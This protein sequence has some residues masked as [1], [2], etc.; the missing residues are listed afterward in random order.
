MSLALQSHPLV[1]ENMG[2][3][4]ACANRF[5]NRGVPYDD[6]FQAGCVG[7]I[8]AA[9]GFDDTRGFKF[10]TY[11]VP[12][13]LGEIKRIFRDGGSVKIGR[14]AKEKGRELLKIYE[15]L[16]DEKGREPDI[17]EVARLAGTEV[18]EAAL[19]LSASLPAVSPTSREDS[20][21]NDIPVESP[22]E[23]CAELLDLNDALERLNDDERQL[24]K[25][26]YFEFMTQCDTAKTLGMTQV[27]V[28]R[29]EKGIL[30][31][32]R[33]MLEYDKTT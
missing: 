4:H 15:R 27:Q 28:S 7:L 22:E 5:R 23:S 17:S 25:C 32:L 14:A 21:E 26:R 13:I 31:K 30:L 10:S 2:L 20:S 8:K 12:A 3:V 24:I 1:V 11:A 18:T 29:R 19:I 6:L 16:A 9:S 33:K